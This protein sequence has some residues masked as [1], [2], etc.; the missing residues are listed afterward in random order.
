MMHERV[1][2]PA[3]WD[4]DL[5]RAY[6]ELG[7]DRALEPLAQQR[8]RELAE[9]MAP[10]DPQQQLAVALIVEASHRRDWT[11]TWCYGLNVTPAGWYSI[12]HSGRWSEYR[13]AQN[14]VVG[15]VAMALE[16][17]VPRKVCAY[18]AGMGV[19]RVAQIAHEPAR[20]RRLTARMVEKMYEQ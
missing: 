12:G 5:V 13:L 9:M 14:E 18:A 17:D 20:Q 8:Q 10:L 15:I 7:M 19:A 3:D 4:E 11:V 16:L 1:P 6:Y 2:P